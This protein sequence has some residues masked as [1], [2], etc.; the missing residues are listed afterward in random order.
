MLH[1]SNPQRPPSETLLGHCVRLGQLQERTGKT[2]EALA[3]LEECVP[4]LDA[5]AFPNRANLLYHAHLGRSRCLKQLGKPAEA[6]AAA[7]KAQAA[8]H[9]KRP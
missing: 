8:L 6:E 5:G 3:W 7:E 2:E 1:R 9:E 4:V